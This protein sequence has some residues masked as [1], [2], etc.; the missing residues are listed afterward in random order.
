MLQDLA[1][2]PDRRG[3]QFLDV[4]VADHDLGTLGDEPPRDRKPDAARPAGDQGDPA[5]QP[6]VLRH[7]I[8]RRIGGAR[9]RLRY[10]VASLR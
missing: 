5:P 9:D 10:C 1:V 8:G 3:L 6:S 4:D 2:G 7:R